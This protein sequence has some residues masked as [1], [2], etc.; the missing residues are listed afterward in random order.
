MPAAVARSPLPAP[1]DARVTLRGIGVAVVHRDGADQPRLERARPAAV[2]RTPFQFHE[3]IAVRHAGNAVAGGD[4][5]G[6]VLRD[7]CE[8]FDETRVDPACGDGIAPMRA[9][10]AGRAEFDAFPAGGAGIGETR[11]PAA[12]E[13]GHDL[14][15][16][17][18][19]V[20]RHLD[21]PRGIGGSPAQAQLVGVV[22]RRFEIAIE[23]GRAIGPIRHFVQGRR[24]ETAAIARIRFSV[25]ER[26][27][28]AER[29]RGIC[30][31]RPAAV[32]AINEIAIFAVEAQPRTANA[33]QR[34]PV[35]GETIVRR[36]IQI[37]DIDAIVLVSTQTSAHTEAAT[38]EIL[39]PAPVFVEAYRFHADRERA[40]FATPARCSIDPGGQ[41]LKIDDAASTAGRTLRRGR[42]REVLFHRAIGAIRRG[43]QF[44]RARTLATPIHAELVFAHGLAR[45]KRRRH[46]IGAVGVAR[47]RVPR[48]SQR[49]LRQWLAQAVVDHAQT[50]AAA[51]RPFADDIELMTPRRAVRPRALGGEAAAGRAP[52]PGVVAASI[53]VAAAIDTQT[54]STAAVAARPDV[55]RRARRRIEFAEAHDHA[56]R[57]IAV[58]QS[59]RSAQHFDAVER[60]QRKRRRLP[61]PVGG[62]GGNAVDDQ[63]DPADPERRAC[64]EAA[65]LDLQILREILPIERGESGHPL[66][67]FRQIHLALTVAQRGAIEHRD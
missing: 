30:V 18:H 58:L 56:T 33:G 4:D 35:L 48:Q 55:E 65:R 12:I 40:A 36:R 27:D 20:Q 10:I 29:Q 47:E 26:A 11:A 7:E 37:D 51:R 59:Q 39:E 53:I 31:A 22:A 62:A 28:Y 3:R 43:P 8:A 5:A 54:R 23:S 64:A 25:R 57:G 14:V 67:R 61:L 13:R 38:D 15:F 50:L 42:H 9:E 41:A 63:A 6:F 60:G 66:Q 16:A 21:P 46:G 44:D 45:I 52:A 17:I 32:V 19:P 49:I 24:L 2:V 1:C 34:G